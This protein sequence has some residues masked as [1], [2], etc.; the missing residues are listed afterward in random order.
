MADEATPAGATPRSIN[1]RHRLTPL[2]SKVM[3]YRHMF[4]VMS[5]GI[6]LRVLMRDTNGPSALAQLFARSSPGP[7]MQGKRGGHLELYI[8]SA[9]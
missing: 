4:L 1:E 2:M 5:R 3:E 8:I 9:I 7:D 6:F